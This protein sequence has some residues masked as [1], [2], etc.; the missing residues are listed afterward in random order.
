MRKLQV[1]DLQ[2]GQEREVE[3]S[4]EEAHE[5]LCKQLSQA[6][7]KVVYE[8]GMASNIPFPLAA[9]TI[10]NLGDQMLSL[11]ASHGLDIT[12]KQGRNYGHYV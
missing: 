2:T 10:A 1:L 5:A 3:V 9:Q 12:P 6:V 7:A 8:V 4:E 11:A